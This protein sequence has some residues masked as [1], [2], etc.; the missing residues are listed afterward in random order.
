[1]SEQGDMAWECKLRGFTKAISGK[2]LETG[3]SD[4]SCYCNSKNIVK[5]HSP[6]FHCRAQT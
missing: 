2:L 3:C 5:W 1:M 6:K 4:G